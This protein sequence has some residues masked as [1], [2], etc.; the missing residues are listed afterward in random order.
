MGINNKE[1]VGRYVDLYLENESI[2]I[3][4]LHASMQL[5]ERKLIDSWN[6]TIPAWSW[7]NNNG[8]TANVVEPL[9]KGGEGSFLASVKPYQGHEFQISKKKIKDK[10]LKIRLE[11]KD[12]I[13]QAE[14]IIFP[15]DSKR[16]ETENWLKVVMK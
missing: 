16:N 5:G 2:G 1:N 6:D 15:V 10:K 3:V 12:F 9:N 4:N 14:D 8:W 7:G 11:I 13:G